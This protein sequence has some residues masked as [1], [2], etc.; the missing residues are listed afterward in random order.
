VSN[1]AHPAGQCNDPS[2]CFLW[3]N[4]APGMSRSCL[5]ATQTSSTAVGANYLGP[6]MPGFT[7]DPAACALP[8]ALGQSGCPS[9]GTSSTLCSV[10]TN[11]ST[12]MAAYTNPCYN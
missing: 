7:P 2:K 5:N 11:S 3:L 6:L 8:P 10:K 9:L 4:T 1:I 12:G